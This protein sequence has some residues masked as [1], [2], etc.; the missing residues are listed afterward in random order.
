[1]KST[2]YLHIALIGILALS[3]LLPLKVILE[4]EDSTLKAPW[5]YAEAF[6]YDALLINPLS[7]S[8]IM[9]NIHRQE[10]IRLGAMICYLERQEKSPPGLTALEFIHSECEV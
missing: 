9:Y 10:K 2:R 8:S 5:K 4:D 7:C 1:M 6:C 3:F